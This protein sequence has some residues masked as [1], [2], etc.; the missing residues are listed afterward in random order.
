MRALVFGDEKPG[1]LPLDA[2]GDEHRPRLGLRLHPGRD[3]RRFA[4]HFAGRID[5]DRAVGP[6]SSS[7]FL[8]ILKI[9]GASED[10]NLWPLPSE[11]SVVGL[12]LFAG[13][14]VLSTL[15]S[16]AVCFPLRPL[17]LGCYR[18]RE[19]VC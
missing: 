12:L 17:P 13:I 8:Q 14:C 19:A 7:M 3:V 11:G 16:K 4:E 5:H 2:R 9:V 10:S 15:A 1:C 18:L 6:A